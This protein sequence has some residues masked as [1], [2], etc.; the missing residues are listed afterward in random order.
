MIRHLVLLATSAVCMSLHAQSPVKEINRIKLDSCYISAEATEDTEQK[1]EEAAKVALT[2]RVKEVF[3][4]LDLEAIRTKVTAYKKISME[5]GTRHR[6]FL[7]I[8][9]DAVPPKKVEPVPD[10]PAPVAP[11]ADSSLKQ[12]QQ[13]LIGGLVKCVDVEEVSNYLDRVKAQNKVT[14]MGTKSS[15]P[16]NPQKAFYVY[17]DS[18]LHTMA[19]LGS[20]DSDKRMNYMTNKLES[21]KD[22]SGFAY[23]WFVLPN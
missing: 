18:S 15:Q 14:L 20:E 10:A 23:I 1:A 11:V 3:P 9:N 7:F 16:R 13:N 6:V 19:V 2:F 17:F 5:R 8:P 22:Y 21:A 4:A 12:W